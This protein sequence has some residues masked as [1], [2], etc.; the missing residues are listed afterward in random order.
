MQKPVSMAQP[1]ETAICW[2]TLISPYPRAHQCIGIQ[3]TI[4]LLDFNYSF[5]V[6][7]LLLA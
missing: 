7:I 4:L 5:G 1:Q 2:Q 3:I 6:M